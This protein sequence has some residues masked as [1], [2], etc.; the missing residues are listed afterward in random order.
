MDWTDHGVIL[1]Q[2]QVPWLGGRLGYSMWAPDCVFKNGK[3][4]FY[5]PA[6]NR[7]GVAIADK[8]Y[9]PFK[10]EAQSMAGAGGIDPGILIDDDGSAYMFW[11][12]IQMVKLKDNMLE[13]D[14]RAQRVQN[15]P[16]DGGLIEGPFPL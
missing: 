2:T 6:S 4:Y 16:N 5:F 12:G 3:Y 10:A 14:G 1:T 7:I 9:G 11:S 13:M 8:P 15:L